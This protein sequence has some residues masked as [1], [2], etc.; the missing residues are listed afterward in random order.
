MSSLFIRNATIVT[1]DDD[2][3]TVEG[4]IYINDG[5]SFAS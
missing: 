4:S 2:R 1:M 5:S 3:N